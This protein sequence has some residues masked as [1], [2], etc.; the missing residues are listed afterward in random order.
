MRA[1]ERSPEELCSYEFSLTSWFLLGLSNG[2][3]EAVIPVNFDFRTNSSSF[4]A[5]LF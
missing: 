2:D 3:A 1:A 4:R 5:P